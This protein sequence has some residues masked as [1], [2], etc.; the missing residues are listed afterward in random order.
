LKVT[1]EDE[2]LVFRSVHYF[3]EIGGWRW[4]LPKALEPGRME[5]AHRDEG[6]GSFSFRLTLTHRIWGC[7]VHQLAYFR[8][9][10]RI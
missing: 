6:N 8:D 1:V 10:E 7:A 3:F 4:R 5:I 9:P 2:A